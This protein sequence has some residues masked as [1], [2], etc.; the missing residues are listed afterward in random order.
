MKRILEIGTLFATLAIMGIPAVSAQGSSNTAR[1]Q[2][3]HAIHD[4]NH[5]GI[6][7]VCGLPTGSGQRNAQGQMAKN[8][9]HWGPG[10]GTGNNSSG[11]RDGTGFG[12][13]SGS[14]SGAQD[15]TGARKGGSAMR[16]PG[17]RAG[18]S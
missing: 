15:G 5:D 13:Q 10:D 11:P 1:K 3:Q 17:R 9:K 18:R 7:D 2:T 14:R 8:G 4:Q 16:G 6:C 12:A